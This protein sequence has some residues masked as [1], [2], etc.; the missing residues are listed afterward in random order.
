[1]RRLPILAAVLLA[2]TACSTT[3]VLSDGE[4][5]LMD[6]KVRIAPGTPLQ[7]SDVT[8]RIRQQVGSSVIFGWSPALGIYNLQNGSDNAWGR[9]C[10]K[11]GT[12]PVVYR[13]SQVEPSCNNIASHLEALGYY[14]SRVSA[15]VSCKNKKATVTYNV[16][17]GKRYRIDK[18][19]YDIPSGTFSTDFYADTLH[20][21]VRPGEWLSESL[22]EAE[23][24][25]SSAHMR[26][27]GYYGF[28]K[29]NFS[30][31]A[32]TVS[33][34][35]RT[36]LTYRVRSYARGDAL[37]T[38]SDLRKHHIGEVFIAHSK[39]LPFREKVL[40]GI[41]TIHPGDL[42][43]EKAINTA[44]S[45]LS[46][47]K[48]FNSIGIELA[49]ADSVTLDCRIKLTESKIQGFKL[50]FESSLNSSG[51]LGISPQLSY[52]HKNIFHGGEWLNVSVREN[53][54]F[55]PSDAGTHSNE[56]SASASI[57]F[58]KFLG[59]PY[60][61]FS[62][63]TI[64]RTEV[65]AAYS[66]QD[67]PE[68]TRSIASFSFGYTVL[69]KEGVSM[70]I[71]PLAFSYVSLSDMDPTF[72]AKLERNPYI[73]Y[74]YQNHIDAGL[75]A[76]LYHTT[77]VDIVPRTAYH[78]ER[79]SLNVSGNLLYAV[80]G[81]LPKNGVGQ[82][83]VFGAPYAQYVRS[84]VTLGRT[85]RWG[86]NDGV[87]LATRFL[88][89]A[90]YA[91]GN[92]SALPFEQQ[93]Y[94]GGANSLR[95]WQARSVGPGLAIPSTTFSIPSQTGDLKLE[96]NLELRS[97]LFWKFEGAL[98]ADVG[99]VWSLR[100]FDSLD[101]EYKESEFNLRDF[102]K[103]LAADWGVGLRLDLS[104]ILLRLD[105]GFKLHDPSRAAG[106][107]WVSPAG[108]FASDGLAFHFGVGYPF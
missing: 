87:A 105:L 94:V 43:N 69:P 77:N 9:F 70:Q 29:G 60:S 59:L 62:G 102:Y 53:Y 74:S 63:P 68:F 57:S 42:Y 97:A 8:S 67:R 99:N 33:T 41:N 78:Y 82:G 52:F 65:K 12:A 84:E 93:F 39:S 81:A 46:G 88:A 18:V 95:G 19:L 106:S 23:S 75:S 34:P 76:I 83:L 85:F 58:P 31:E 45:R 72:S 73:R 56:F 64:P 28:T 26:E 1:M 36:V 80:R 71:S 15:S 7:P 3:R 32:D 100:R 2:F 27:Q 89:G 48:L 54:Q 107:R 13:E 86:R 92:S 103:S 104:V 22:L 66:Y 20:S 25:R 101:L 5:R 96:A 49:P 98:F 37:Q 21:L 108:W 16:V 79:V 47:L 61:A 50:N 55:K 17:P 10:R 51:L 90:G 4:Y 35:G 11:L 30:F 14:N 6:N 24:A 44:Y 91:Y 38:D 40:R